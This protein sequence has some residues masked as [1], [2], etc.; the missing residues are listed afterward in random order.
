MFNLY[1][2]P[3]DYKTRKAL[4]CAK[5]NGL[6]IVR[7]DITESNKTSAPFGK[8]PVLETPQ[9]C[10]FST[11]AIVRYLART[12]RDLSLYGQT[13]LENGQVDSWLEFSTSTL[14]VPLCTI[15]YPILGLTAAIPAASEQAKTDVTDSLKILEKH[16]LKKT[17][18]VGKE[19]TAADIS[20]VCALADAFSLAFDAA[21]RDEFPN[22]LK[23]FNLVMNQSAVKEVFGDYKFL[24]GGGI[25]PVA[26]GK[27]DAQKQPKAKKEPKAKAKAEAKPEL[28]PEELKKQKLKKVIKE[29]GKRGVEI[30]G[31]AD[32]GGL[33]FF[34]NSVDEP[35][36]D[37]ELLEE[38]L[39]AMCAECKPEDEE[40]KGGAGNVGKMV[41]SSGTE[42]LAVICD[43]PESKRDKLSAKVWME[44]VMKKVGGELI[45]GSD[46]VATGAVKADSNKGIFPIKVKD[47]A[48]SISI[49]FLKQKGLFPDGD[50]DSD[51]DYVF[52]DEDFPQ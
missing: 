37:L 8:V 41:F 30:E 27:A 36:G 33:E 51:D 22:V 42:Q 45:K 49:D 2:L 35:D 11:N 3:D 50:D 10:I 6:D 28:T 16:L 39:K 18:V 23:W 31:A 19:M 7:K 14:E 13:F 43:V 47:T 44:D 48:I 32:M 5:H 34:C 38:S 40:R 52:G 4:I 24:G 21:F 9:G 20:L 25:T 12:R 1:A 29:G 26:Q 15:T 46:A 17:Y